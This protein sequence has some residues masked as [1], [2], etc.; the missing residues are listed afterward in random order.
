MRR[1]RA[2][3]GAWL[4][5]LPQA[6]RA[7]PAYPGHQ[8]SAGNGSTAH[9]LIVVIARRTRAEIIHVP[10]RGGAPPLNDPFSGRIDMVFDQMPALMPLV[11]T[12]RLLPLA[13][14]SMARMS[15]LLDVPG[16]GE[17]TDLGIG[18]LDLQS[19]NAV[20]G[21]GGMAPGLVQALHQGVLRAAA[22]PGLA[23]RFGLLGLTI[24]VSESP[25]AVRADIA[26]EAGPWAEMVRLSDARMGK[27]FSACNPWQPAAMIWLCN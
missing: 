25:A 21:P 7:R 13:V 18:D 10:Y 17:F 2:G 14:G 24:S 4:D 20:T 23:D 1:G 22:A 19:W 12:G 26:R 15:L 8:G 6:D 3:T 5:R 16:M 11:A 27:R 9:L